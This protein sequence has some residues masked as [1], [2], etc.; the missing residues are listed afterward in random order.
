MIK[1]HQYLAKGKKKTIS[2]ST[3]LPKISVQTVLIILGLIVLV[4]FEPSFVYVLDKIYLSRFSD[5]LHILYLVG[6]AGVR[7]AQNFSTFFT[8]LNIKRM[9]VTFPDYPD[10]FQDTYSKELFEEFQAVILQS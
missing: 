4:L 1:H 6:M 3:T 8:L 2:E 10:Y 7:L 5:S 9:E